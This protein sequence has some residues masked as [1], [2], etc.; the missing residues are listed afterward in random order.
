MIYSRIPIKLDLPNLNSF[1]KFNHKKLNIKNLVY[2]LTVFYR[3]RLH[4][5]VKSYKDYRRFP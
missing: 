4:F 5:L 3:T 2:A 1:W